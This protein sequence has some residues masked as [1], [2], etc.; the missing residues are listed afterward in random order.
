MDRCAE[1]YTSFSQ[2]MHTGTGLALA[3]R[4][5]SSDIAKRRRRH[6]AGGVG[7]QQA[8]AHQ[9][10]LEQGLRP[11]L[12]WLNFSPSHL[13]VAERCPTLLQHQRRR[14]ESVGGSHCAGWWV[15]TDGIHPRPYLH[16]WPRR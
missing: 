1:V 16:A 13:Q 12:R 4:F 2:T 9:Q 11:A 15:G 3:V 8:G 14:S 6:A 5:T 7:L 10:R